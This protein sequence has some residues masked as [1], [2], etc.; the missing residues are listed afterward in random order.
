[1]EGKEGGEKKGKWE[2]QAPEETLTQLLDNTQ[3]H[4]AHTEHIEP[5]LHAATQRQITISEIPKNLKHYVVKNTR[6]R[7]P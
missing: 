4:F 6:R 1:M 3:V 5:I 2:D 7:H